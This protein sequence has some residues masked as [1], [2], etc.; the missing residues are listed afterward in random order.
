MYHRYKIAYLTSKNPT[1]RTE[2]SGVY[3]YQSKA[4]EKYSGDVTHLGPVNSLLIDF[5]R[6]AIN[7]LNRFLPRKISHSHSILISKIYGKIFTEKL[8]NKD[9]DLIFSDKSSSELAFLKTSIPII[10]ST[11]ATFR[12][13]HNYYPN[14]SNL[15]GFSESNGNKIE[16]RA[17]N[18]ASIIACTS[19]WAKN[20][21]VN[22]YGFPASRVHV[23]PRGANIDRIIDTKRIGKRRKNGV[24][25]LVFVGHE[26]ERKGFDIAWQTMDFIRAQGV[27]VKLTAIGLVPPPQYTDADVNVIP[28]IDKNTP[29]GSRQ[30]DEIMF[31]SDFYLMPTRAECVAIAF[32]EAAAYGIPVITRDTGGVTE[33]VKNGI[34]GFVMNPDED[35]IAYGRRILEIWH[36]DDY[37]DLV[38][39]S[40]QYFEERLNW[41][42]WGK[43]FKSI[44]DDFFTRDKIPLKMSEYDYR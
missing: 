26:W 30:F 15:I 35:H 32:C 7:F 5:I 3:Y 12:L 21:I 39:S 2:S 18:N 23:L 24:L 6:K 10:Y 28:F 27:M 31:N 42:I 19:E 22:D 44:L 29:E 40:R 25:R 34:N 13:L 8:K 14:Y 9:F 11:D 36:S 4:L 20:S 17:I 37:Y 41:D 43:R 1:D 38:M 33:V 16:Q